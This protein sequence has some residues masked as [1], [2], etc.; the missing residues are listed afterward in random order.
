MSTCAN[1]SAS[2]PEDAQFCPACGQGTHDVRRPLYNLGREVMDDYLGINGKLWRTLGALAIPGRLTRAYLGGQ[3][4]RYVRPLRLY[5]SVTVVFFLL[6]TLFD[7]AGQARRR[8]AELAAPSDV[9]H[10]AQIAHNLTTLD[11]LA[12]RLATAEAGQDRLAASH[13]VHVDSVRML[14]KATTLSA[15]IGLDT[16]DAEMDSSAVEGEALHE[17]PAAVDTLS[18]STSGGG[19]KQWFERTVEKK[20]RSADDVGGLAGSF[21]SRSLRYTPNLIFVLLPLFALM[22][23]LLYVRRSRFYGEHMVFAL[24]VHACWFALGALGLIVLFV[25]RLAGQAVLPLLE[26]VAGVVGAL[27]LIYLF[28]SLYRIYRQ[29][30]VKTGVKVAMLGGLY[31]FGAVV[32]WSTLL[33]GVILL[34]VAR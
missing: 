13:A 15:F 29:G 25:L 34:E 24:H 8:A 10:A 30:I 27:C 19:V 18:V 20:L 16:L 28:V 4:V 33:F 3:R 32:A 21:V 6:L 1:C 31:L 17:E 12:L 26:P 5:L 7:P 2:L 11:S 14:L 9:R 23:K 22:L